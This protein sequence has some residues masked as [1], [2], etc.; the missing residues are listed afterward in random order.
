MVRSIAADLVAVAVR[1][2]R[3]ARQRIR[4]PLG[5]A[6]ARRL[7]LIDRHGG[8][9]MSQ[10]AAIDHCSLPTTTTQVRLLI[11]AGLVSR[12]VDPDDA[13]AVL[14]RITPKGAATLRRVRVDYGVAIN[15]DLN[16]LSVAD[17]QTLNDAVRVL[18]RFS[19]MR[20]PKPSPNNPNPNELKACKYK[21]L[22]GL[23]RHWPTAH[24]RR[25]RYSSRL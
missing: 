6:Q 1:I 11:Q 12:T 16:R 2:D 15:S 7:A 17:R 14:V 25:R 23:S 19:R 10:L 4:M 3:I 22:D 13:R 9:R 21:S 24:T 18:Q 20:P 5:Y 8:A